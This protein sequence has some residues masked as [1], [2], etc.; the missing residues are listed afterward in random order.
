MES[1]FGARVQ[2]SWGMTEL[3][4]LG[5]IASPDVPASKARASGRPVMGLDMK[6][7]DADGVTLTQQRGKVGHLKIKGASVI[8][9]YFK[10]GASALDADGYFESGDLASIDD[11]GNVSICGRSKDLIKSG[12]EWIN[13]TEIEEI[14]GAHPAVALAAVIGRTDE[15]WGERPV[16]I[17]EWATGHSVN[18]RALL[19]SL[20]G[21]VASWWIPDEIIAVDAMP[22]A[23]TGK[24]DKNRLRIDYANGTLCV[25]Q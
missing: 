19:E 9:R 7:T 23:A 15:K 16:L 4:P 17:V 20:R 13:P 18:T 6:L 5:T 22:L 8:E 14:V 10:A 12:G 2:T 3:S 24:I 25:D 11:D 1:R 21:R